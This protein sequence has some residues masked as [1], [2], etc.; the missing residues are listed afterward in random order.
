MIKVFKDG[1]LPPYDERLPENIQ[2]V[3]NNSKTIEGIAM[4]DLF[5]PVVLIQNNVLDMDTNKLLE[6]VE[7]IHSNIL[8]EKNITMFRNEYF[9]LSNFYKDDKGYCVEV[10]FQKAKCIIGRDIQKA[11][12]IETLNNAKMAKKLGRQA[13]L[14]HSHMALWDKQK[15]KI[16]Y[17]LLKNK[18][19]NKDLRNK[20][21]DTNGSKLI[22]GNYWNDTTWG[23][24]I[25]SGEGFNILGR[26]LMKLRKEL[27]DG[28]Y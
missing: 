16:M 14:N 15:Y 23:I 8:H 7:T 28:N 25:K 6:E 12:E 11:N 21:L 3:I 18:F 19:A 17:N 9:F 2:V 24:D 13:K 20:L 26:M 10:E 27:I 22:E 1:S 4:L 5:Y